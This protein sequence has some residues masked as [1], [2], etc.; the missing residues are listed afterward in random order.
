MFKN[1]INV[2]VGDIL[3]GNMPYS[4]IA[5]SNLL[6]NQQAIPE[7]ITESV[8]QK[9]DE[10][11][12]FNVTARRGKDLLTSAIRR[13]TILGTVDGYDQEVLDEIIRAL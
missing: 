1:Q 2:A 7:A 10:A 12:Q 6:Y 5:V 11:A 4:G 13:A 9:L 8:Q 3:R